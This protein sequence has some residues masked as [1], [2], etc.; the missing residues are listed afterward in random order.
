MEI[1][2]F[3]HL[4]DQ[5]L[6]QLS[7]AGNAAGSNTVDYIVVAGG[8]GGGGTGNGGGGGAGG[9]REDKSSCTAYTASPLE[10]CSALPVTATAYPITV[11]GGGA[12][13]LRPSAR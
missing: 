2:K 12:G 13:G 9:F 4:Q 7:C 10:L 11:G 3:I 1:V 5:E 8:G 6:L